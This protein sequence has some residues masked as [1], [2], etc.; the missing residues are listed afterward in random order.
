ME[1]KSAEKDDATI[2]EEQL[3]Q[4]SQALIDSF[5]S[6]IKSGRLCLGLSE[7]LDLLD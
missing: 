2:F 4:L 6:A 5:N 3:A 1:K 7:S